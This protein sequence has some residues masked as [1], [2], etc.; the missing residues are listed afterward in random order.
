MIRR[1][2]VKIAYPGKYFSGSQIQPNL[3]TVEGEVILSLKTVSKIDDEKWFNLK[4][5]SRTDSG[6]NSTGNVIVFNTNFDSNFNLLSALNAVSK[7]VYYL[8]IADVSEDFNPR[9]ANY[10]IYEYVIQ[11]DGMDVERIK[12]CS[13]LFVGEHDFVRFSKTDDKNTVISIDEILVEEHEKSIVLTFKAQHFLWN[14]IRRISAAIISVGLGKSLVSDVQNALDGKDITFGLAR[15]DA[16]TLTDVFYKDLI[17]TSYNTES[18]NNRVEE[19]LFENTL[20]NNF[21]NSLRKNNECR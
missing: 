2:A 19:K 15:P 14:M 6:V 3:P 5:A 11:K 9:H 10:R 20:E 17:F 1:V 7:N 18:L 13:S 8:S 21:Y 4:C 16:L 12:Q